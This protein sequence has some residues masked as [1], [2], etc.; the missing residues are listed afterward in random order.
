MSSVYHHYIWFLRLDI[1][2][3]IC[4]RSVEL[5]I[6]WTLIKKCDIRLNVV[7][8]I[9][10]AFMVSLAKSFPVVQEKKWPLISVITENS[11]RTK[12]KIWPVMSF[13]R[14]LFRPLLDFFILCQNKTLRALFFSLSSSSFSV[15]MEA[16][17][18][19]Y[20]TLLF[21][22]SESL[23][24]SFTLHFLILSADAV[25]FSNFGRPI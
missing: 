19:L 16:L 6:S 17:F 20:L 8:T 12:G 24:L 13:D 22:F 1:N 2:Q 11:G 5:D 25:G 4:D 3:Q 14:P 10:N 23:L 21:S 18:W 9:S 7:R 15:V